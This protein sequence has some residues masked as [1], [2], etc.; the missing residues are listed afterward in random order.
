MLNMPARSER[1]RAESFKVD[2]HEDGAQRLVGAF[3]EK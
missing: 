2:A 1:L 3:S